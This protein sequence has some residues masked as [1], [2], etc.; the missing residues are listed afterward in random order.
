MIDSLKDLGVVLF[1]KY[2]EIG[3]VKSRLT[4]QIDDGLTVELYKSFILDHISTLRKI[5][6]SLIICVQPGD[7]L[8]EFDKWLGADYSYIPQRGSDLGEKLKNAF[9][10][11]FSQGFKE[12]IVMASDSPDLPESVLLEAHRELKIHDVVI[13]PTIDGG[14]YLIGFK[15]TSF[16]PE[17]FEDIRWSTSVVFKQ[18]IEKFNKK[19]YNFHILP[20]WRDVDTFDDLKDLVKRGMNTDFRYSNTMNLILKQKKNFFAE[21]DYPFLC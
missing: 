12:A 18:T 10:D 21:R 8:E 4:S 2:P 5:K 20:L 15:N 13:G 16:L 14:Y 9:R 17:T 1:V 19:G 11:T 6:T 7:K 3:N